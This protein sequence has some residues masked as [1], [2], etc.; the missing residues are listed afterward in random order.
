MKT[1]KIIIVGAGP[2]GLTAGMILAK[3]GFQVTFYEKEKQVGGRNGK[4]Q[5]KDYCFDIGP[6]FLMM[7]PVLEEVFQLA[8]RRAHDYLKMTKLEPMYRLSFDKD[9]ELLASSDSEKMQKELERFSKGSSLDYLKYLKREKKKFETLMPCLKVP[10]SKWTDLLRWQLIRSIP[11]LDIHKT[12]METLGDYFKDPF[13]RTAFTF[14]AKYIGMS[15]WKAPGL[16][17]MISYIEHGGGVFHVEGGLHKISEAMAKV[18][19]E[20]GGTINLGTPVKR[21]LIEN[22]KAV[23]VELADGTFDKADDVI[24]NA[25][26]AYAMTHLVPEQERKK[27][28]NK[29][30]KNKEYSCSTFMLYLGVK[31]EFPD[32]P[33]HSIVFAKDY[34]KNVEEIAE[35]QILSED[36]SFYVQNASVTDPTLA[37]KGKSTLY[38]LIPVPNNESHIDW[39]SEKE[40]IKERLIKAMEE[41]GGYKDLR[42]N[43]EESFVITP[44][45][46]ENKRHVYKGA[47]FNLSHKLSQMLI[48]RPH[49]E[50]EDFK[51]AYLVGGGTHPGSGLPTIYESGRISAELILK[52]SLGKKL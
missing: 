21:V 31:K 15:P 11:Y 38:V 10:Y 36:F 51:N 9:K 2:G 22:N 43:I 48:F 19:E 37:P 5:L 39:E 14:Q 49:N 26:F 13:V 32:I 7:L 6:T 40:K 3:Q 33:H 12:L 42:E 30:L 17:S 47:T 8:G 35:T 25:D 45:D 28:D 16:F 18:V 29:T 20:H 46:W 34:K 24:L 41:R 52:K 1:K 23:G 44:S 27:Y 50:F 4:I